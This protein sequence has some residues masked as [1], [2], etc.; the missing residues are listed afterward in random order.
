MKMSN[1]KCDLTTEFLVAHFSDP[2]LKEN[3]VAHVISANKQLMEL[4][5]VKA[6]LYAHHSDPPDATNDVKI[7]T[8]GKTTKGN[9]KKHIFAHHSDPPEGISND[10]KIAVGKATMD[11]KLKKHLFAH[12]SDPPLKKVQ[13]QD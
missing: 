3:G 5:D 12:H 13:L 6:H 2:P 4:A 10:V 9:V 8:E 7:V 1:R 11:G